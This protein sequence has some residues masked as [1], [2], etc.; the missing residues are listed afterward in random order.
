MCAGPCPTHPDDLMAVLVKIRSEAD[1][2]EARNLNQGRSLKEKVNALESSL[3]RHYAGRSAKERGAAN[4]ECPRPVSKIRTPSES[5]ANAPTTKPSYYEVTLATTAR[6]PVV[7]TVT[8]GRP[9][10]SADQV[11]KKQRQTAILLALWWHYSRVRGQDQ[12]S[13]R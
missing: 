9:V 11:M 2:R 7:G 3:S 10:P 4:T 5:R 12:N 6:P 8:N 13:G 1:D